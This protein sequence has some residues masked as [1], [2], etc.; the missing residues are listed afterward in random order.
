MQDFSSIHLFLINF[1]EKNCACSKYID[2]PKNTKQILKAVTDP[3]N[4]LTATE[5]L[6]EIILSKPIPRNDSFIKLFRQK[7]S[8]EDL[9]LVLHR[10]KYKC[11][12]IVMQ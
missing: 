8:Q 5:G 12:Q 1:A 11:H 9:V 7:S 4:N 6:Q 3:E 2:T 10:E